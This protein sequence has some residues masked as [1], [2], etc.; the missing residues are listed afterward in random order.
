MAITELK[1]DGMTCGGCVTSVTKALKRVAG[2]Q[3]VEVD[4]GRGT[5]RVSADG[6]GKQVPAMLAALTEA[7]YQAS[8]SGGAADA[9]AARSAGACHGGTGQD[10]RKGHGG[11]GSCCGH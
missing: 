2:V 3:G 5:A 8:V 9:A 11:G 10:A 6:A 4:L 7:G 1:I